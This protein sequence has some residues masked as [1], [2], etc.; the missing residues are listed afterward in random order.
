MIIH[1]H[2]SLL[3]AFI[4]SNDTSQCNLSRRLQFPRHPWDP[5]FDSRQNSG[6]VICKGLSSVLWHLEWYYRWCWSSRLQLWRQPI[7]PSS[8]PFSEE[9]LRWSFG[10]SQAWYGY[11]NWHRKNDTV[12]KWEF[13]SLQRQ[14]LFSHHQHWSSAV[15]WKNWARLCSSYSSSHS[16][17]CF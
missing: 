15:I 10:K 13:G 14:N 17:E 6:F 1:S 9:I 16:S 5:V 2:L 7:S 11:S 3:Y 4:N 8:V 12:C